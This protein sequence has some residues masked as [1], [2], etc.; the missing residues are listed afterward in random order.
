L[1]Y[2]YWEP[3]K[4]A[5]PFQGTGSAD[6]RNE[7][8]SKFRELAVCLRVKM[9][10]HS[11]SSQVKDKRGMMIISSSSLLIMLP[12]ILTGVSQYMSF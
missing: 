3:Q 9:T 8:K 11:R 2:Y 4:N 10:P 7:I 5:I 1:K 6:I 12:K